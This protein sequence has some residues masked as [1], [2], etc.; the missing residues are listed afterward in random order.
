MRFQWKAVCFILNKCS[1]S[2]FYSSTEFNDRKS[3]FNRD[4]FSKHNNYVYVYVKQNYKINIFT[5]NKKIDSTFA[6]R[7]GHSGSVVLKLYR[8]FLCMGVLCVYLECFVTLSQDI[9][10]YYGVVDCFFHLISYIMSLQF[11]YQSILTE[12]INLFIL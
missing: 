11:P 8:H 5:Q 9:H 2:L 1:R 10:C 12:C 3:E 4:K 7:S 6:W